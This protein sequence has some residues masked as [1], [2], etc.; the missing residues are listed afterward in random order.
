MELASKN[1]Q[2]GVALSL[3]RENGVYNLTVVTPDR[4]NLFASLAGHSVFVR[5]EY[6]ESG[7]VRKPA[8]RRV[9]H[10][11]FHRSHAD[12]GT[13]SRRDGALE[14]DT[15]TGD[16]AAKRTCGD[17]LR[18]RQK[19]SASKRAEVKPTVAFD[20]DASESAT[21]VEIVAEDRPGLLYDLASTFSS[22][23]CSIEVV[24]IDT[25]A[26]KA[27]DVFYVTKDGAK[28]EPDSHGDL[29]ERILLV[30]NN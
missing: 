27:V 7:S 20:G 25:E 24:L 4:P 6:R 30:C 12:A 10:I 1:A 29:R 18:G 28:L 5:N 2:V 8:W 26:H 16:H 15:A 9:G 13:E 21:L 23:G 22:A 19:P 14:S 3:E 17:L 11:F